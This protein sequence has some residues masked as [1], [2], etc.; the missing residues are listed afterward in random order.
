MKPPDARKT[1]V[2]ALLLGLSLLIVGF[3]VGYGYQ[4]PGRATNIPSVSATPIP[5][6][7]PLVK[8]LRASP[9]GRLLAFTGVY[10]RPEQAAIFLLDPHTG[11]WS[12]QESPAGWQDFVTQWASDGRR[13]LVEREKI[14]RAA[15]D[16]S[17]G[18][19]AVPVDPDSGTPSSGTLE[20]LSQGLAPD[21]E[22]II[23]GFWAPGNQL[24][25]KTR[26]E[27]KSLYRVENGEAKLVDHAN[28]TYGQNRAVRV[29]GRLQFLVVR[30]VP[31]Q[32]DAVALYR[33]VDGKASR[34]TPPLSDTVWTYV[35]EDGKQFL[36]SRHAE[37]G[38]NWEWTLYA[39]DGVQAREIKKANVPG[40]VISVYWSPDGKSI[41]GTGGKQLWIVSLPSEKATALGNRQDWQADDA[42][43]MGSTGFVA[44]AADGELWKV[45]VGTGKANKIWRFPPEF[46]H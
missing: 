12:R 39:V 9:D 31:E 33:V 10:G 30:D 3:L 11:K 24:V 35:S 6:E 29:N 2:L 32:E 13:L 28:I 14:P 21:N 1:T 34:L 37:D 25:I 26:R 15:A 7:A 44:V 8:G 17:A 5:P 22:K 41:L 20:P 40:D 45:N 46:W 16:A 38:Q 27:P 19:Y 23:T 43:W 36:V 4:A 42:G 18:L